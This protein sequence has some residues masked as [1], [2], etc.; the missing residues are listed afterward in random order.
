MGAIQTGLFLPRALEAGM[1]C[2]LLLR[3]SGLAARVDTAGELRVNVAGHDGLASLALPGI[4]ALPLA[5]PA[6]CRVLTEAREIAIAVS[7]VRDYPGFAGLLAEA[8]LRKAA[9]GGGTCLLYVCQNEPGAADALTA[10]IIDAGGCPDMFQAL[11]MVIGKMSRT[12]RDPEEIARL[13]LAG[14]FP[15][16]TRAWLVEAYDRIRITRVATESGMVRRLPRL[17]E[18]DDLQPFEIAKL[19]GHN[20]AHAALAYAG[21]RLGMRRLVD[22]MACP[23]ILDLVRDACLLETGAALRCRFGAR[24]ALFSTDGWAHHCEDLFGRMANPWLNDECQRLCRDPDRK[25]GWHDRLV[26]TVRL[27][28]AAG[29][30]ARRWRLAMHGAVEAC[31]LTHDAL[32]RLWKDAGAGDTEI[33]T[34]LQH[35]QRLLPAYA[36]WRRTLLPFRR[37]DSQEKETS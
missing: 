15:G 13:G 28:E 36:E 12:I 10:T 6:C 11:D 2:T 25:L 35:Q 7:S 5:D 14:S 8:T 16:A 30:S 17:E 27:V 31:G 1:A 19:N 32:T 3:D 23:P 22:V 33:M 37:P 9:G 4:R 24:D 29:V 34:M 21:H 26:G 18:H 20:A